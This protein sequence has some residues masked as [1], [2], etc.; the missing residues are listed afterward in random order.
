M[1]ISDIFTSFLGTYTPNTYNI[2]TD[3]IIPAGFAGL[4][5]VYIVKALFLLI[6]FYS[7]WKIIGGVICRK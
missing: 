1:T 4:D 3:V 7:L 2:G 5:V 6:A